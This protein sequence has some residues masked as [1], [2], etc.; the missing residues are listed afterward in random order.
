L[1]LLDLLGSLFSCLSCRLLLLFD[2]FL[3]ESLGFSLLLELILL[4]LLLL[5]LHI[6]L[7]LFE[8]LSLLLSSLFDFEFSSLLLSLFFLFL[9]FELQCLLF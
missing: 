2:L 6:I 8:S 1:F 9:L 5:G 3:D 4:S 7:D